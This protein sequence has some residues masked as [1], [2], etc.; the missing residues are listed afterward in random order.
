MDDHSKTLSPEADSWARDLEV[1]FA[2]YPAFVREVNERLLALVETLEAP[3]AKKNKPRALSTPLP[4]RRVL[5]LDDAELS[6]VLISHYLRGLPV[7]VDFAPSLEHALELCTRSSF[8]ALLVDLELKG[9]TAASLLAA[10]KGVSGAPVLALDPVE[11]SLKAE[12]SALGLGF[13]FY[14]SR[15]LPG[16]EVLSR[17]SSALWPA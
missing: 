5:L 17:I 16:Q 1:A 10:L 7:Q 9:H 11:Y 6:R 8:D 2:P 12:E 3:A 13:E 14:L 4:E 15:S